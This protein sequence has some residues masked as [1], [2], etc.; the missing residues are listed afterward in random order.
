MLCVCVS[1]CQANTLIRSNELRL[2]SDLLLIQ[3]GSILDQQIGVDIIIN[4]AYHEACANYFRVSF[5]FL[6][7][8]RD[9]NPNE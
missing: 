2:A 3:I 1:Y 8:R 9:L 6:F 7:S 4:S 5:C